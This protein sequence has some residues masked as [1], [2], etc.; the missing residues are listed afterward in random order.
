MWRQLFQDDNPFVDWEPNDCSV[1]ECSG[2]GGVTMERWY[3][4]AALVLWPHANR[5]AIKLQLLL[6][7]GFENAVKTLQDKF[8]EQS[9][10]QSAMKWFIIL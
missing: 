1:E 10:C 2:N 9:S 6:H 4:Q 5:V 7:N 3:Q 8:K